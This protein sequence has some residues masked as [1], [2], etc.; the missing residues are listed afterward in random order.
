MGSYISKT[1]KVNVSRFLSVL[2]SGD[3]T[4]AFPRKRLREH[5]SQF[6]FQLKTAFLKKVLD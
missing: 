6:F 2:G 4:G 5:I 1:F 3:E